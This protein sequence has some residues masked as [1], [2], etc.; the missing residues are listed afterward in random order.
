MTAQDGIDQWSKLYGRQIIEDEY[1]EICQSL[2]GFFSLLHE[3]NKGMYKERLADIRNKLQPA[4]TVLQ[5]VRQG[6]PVPSNLI[7]SA[8]ED[9]DKV[10]KLI[11]R[12]EIV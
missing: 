11:D 9:L 8:I 4:V 5:L 1:R 2:S 10:V 6:K 7:D 12:D 3:G